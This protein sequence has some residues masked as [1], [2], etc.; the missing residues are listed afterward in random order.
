MVESRY[1]LARP[2]FED[3]G[4]VG[5]LC[6]VLE[7]EEGIDLGFLRTALIESEEEL[8]RHLEQVEDV[9]RFKNPTCGYEKIYKYVIYVVPTFSN[10]SAIEFDALVV[11][12]DVYDFLYWT[13]DKDTTLD[14]K[15]LG[16]P[17]RLVDVNK[18]ID[19][20][21]EWGT[22]GSSISDG[23]PCHLVSTFVGKMLSSGDLEKH[24]EENLIPTYAA[25]SYA[26]VDAIKQY[27]IHLVV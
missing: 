16:L 11:S 3:C 2:I 18:E 19:P 7:D 14:R 24:I 21:S 22:P 9:P 27:L 8:E 10:P 1:F 13:Q 17:P 25:R 20:M 15:A 5:K 6:G 23:N 4:F 12:N 26:I